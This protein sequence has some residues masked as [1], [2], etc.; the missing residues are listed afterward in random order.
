MSKKMRVNDSSAEK[1]RT[2]QTS[3]GIDSLLIPEHDSIDAAAKSPNIGRRVI[4]RLSDL[5]DQEYFQ[6]KV[7]S[8]QDQ[9]TRSGEK[10]K[11]SKK[12]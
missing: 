6:N 5:M 12:N 2:D 8:V 4:D 3:S 9:K 11:F 10:L 7:Q 1:S